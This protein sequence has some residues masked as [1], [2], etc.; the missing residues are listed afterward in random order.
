M[1]G[2]GPRHIRMLCDNPLEGGF[3]YTPMEVGGMTLDM[4]YML[5]SDRKH[6]RSSGRHR[7]TTVESAV[8]AGMGVDGVIKG[9]AADGSQ[10]SARVVGRSVA[11]QIIEKEEEDAKQRAIQANENNKRCKRK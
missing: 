4:I 6:L 1:G 8:A 5:L 2:I 9:R 10:I 11:R 7:T 3:G